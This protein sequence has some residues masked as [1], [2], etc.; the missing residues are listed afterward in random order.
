MAET[1]EK[2]L[3]HRIQPR[4]WNT[5]CVESLSTFMHLP[6]GRGIRLGLY[7][8][9][10]GIWLREIR[11]GK[12]GEGHE[13]LKFEERTFGGRYVSFM[14]KWKQYKLR[15]EYAGIGEKL[16]VRVIPLKLGLFPLI[17]T[18]EAVSSF[19]K[20]QTRWSDQHG[21]HWNCDRFGEMSLAFSTT[22]EA[23][24]PGCYATAG[25]MKAFVADKILLARTKEFFHPNCAEAFLE[26][27]K[28]QAKAWVQKLGGGSSASALAASLS[29]NR[30]YDFVNNRVITPVSRSWCMDWG[31]WIQFCWDGFLTA[32]MYTAINQTEAEN[33]FINVLD[34]QL[35][36][37]FIPNFSAQQVLHPGTDLNLR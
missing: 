18:I 13:E 37:G 4:D 19:D 32:W 10:T 3:L 25:P 1:I 17:V 11:A 14:V 5:W 2:S 20:S 22:E 26:E 6:S 29:W 8:R 12:W 27:G 15:I 7:E 9:A 23:D 31:G 28:E 21:L 16:V 33:A 30:V 36:E 34:G 24:R 35:P